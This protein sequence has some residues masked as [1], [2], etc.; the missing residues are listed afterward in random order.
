M[1][2][3]SNSVRMTTFPYSAICQL[4][5]DFPNSP[6]N[7]RGLH[8]GTGSLVGKHGNI[9]LT[10][11]HN[12][13]DL[14]YGEARSIEVLVGKEVVG[15]IYGP[16][17]SHEKWKARVAQKRRA[18]SRFD[19][20]GIKLPKNYG[21]SLGR[22]RLDPDPKNFPNVTVAG[23]RGATVVGTPE[24][25]LKGRGKL[26]SSKDP[27]FKLVYGI[28]TEYGVSGGP[29]FYQDNRGLYLQIG[30][31]SGQPNGKTYGVGVKITWDILDNVLNS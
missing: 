28:N 6:S 10:S 30:I 12:V 8:R 27:K 16:F 23:F 18:F 3:V 15:P 19:Y 5:M 4:R 26:L 7:E 11:A 31:H 24:I 13:L 1:E 22:F 21:V 14:A 9:L 17:W 2:Q 25:L 20:T 29:L